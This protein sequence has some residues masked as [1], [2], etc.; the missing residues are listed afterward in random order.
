M[1]REL[2]DPEYFDRGVKPLKV[3]RA[4]MVARKAQNPAS[5]GVFG[6]DNEPRRRS[7][8]LFVTR[9][10]WHYAV[11]APSG[12]DPVKGKVH[13]VRHWEI[14]RLNSVFPTHIAQM[15]KATNAFPVRDIHQRTYVL[16]GENRPRTN[17]RYDE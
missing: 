6:Y 8:L 15:L 14:Q 17:V 13:M 1:P 3:F 2:P 9:T 10:A 16:C 4:E 11:F 5:V 12:N 7:E